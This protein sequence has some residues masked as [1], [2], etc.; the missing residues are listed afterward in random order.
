MALADRERL[1]GDS[2]GVGGVLPDS[3][4]SPRRRPADLGQAAGLSR[5]R[6]SFTSFAPTAT[7]RTEPRRLAMSVR[8]EEHTSELQSPYDLVCRLLLEKKNRSLGDSCDL[9][10]D[11]GTL[12][13]LV[14]RHFPPAAP[15]MTDVIH[16]FFALVD[17]RTCYVNVV[18]AE[19]TAA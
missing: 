15:F 9:P 12:D 2:S 5:C 7:A 16:Y 11:Y 8:S 14:S 1:R 6:P 10:F 4:L 17:L 3:S 18:V 13:F 19:F